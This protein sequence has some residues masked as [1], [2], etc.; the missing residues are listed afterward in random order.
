MDLDQD[1]TINGHTFSAGKGVDV[2]ATDTDA[3]GKVI[4][5]D[6]SQAIKEIQ[7]NQKHA[8]E[9]GTNPVKENKEEAK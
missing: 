1:Y 5:S 8:A 2:S 7:A 6:Y 3:D 4:K 9:Y